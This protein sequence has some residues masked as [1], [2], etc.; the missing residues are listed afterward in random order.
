MGGVHRR[1]HDPAVDLAALTA[2]FADAMTAPPAAVGAV[3]DQ[4]EP[5]SGWLPAHGVTQAAAARRTERL[6]G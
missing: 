5:L 6:A 2:G 4:V 1:L 3:L